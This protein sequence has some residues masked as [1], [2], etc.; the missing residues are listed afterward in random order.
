MTNGTQL[1]LNL[2]QSGM[3]GYHMVLP[4]FKVMILVLLNISG[5]DLIE[6]PRGM[7]L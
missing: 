7:F 5:D 2:I 1:V 3:P 6:T 4:P